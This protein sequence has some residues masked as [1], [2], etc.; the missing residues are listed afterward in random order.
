VCDQVWDGLGGVPLHAG[1]GVAVGVE[2]DAGAPEALLD[3]LWV[4]AGS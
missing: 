2:G 3:D 4:H 1:D